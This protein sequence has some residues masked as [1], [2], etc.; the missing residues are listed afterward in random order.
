FESRR[1]HRAEP[2]GGFGTD[3]SFL[4]RVYEKYNAN[5]E[6][7]QNSTKFETYYTG[8]YVPGASGSEY[9]LKATEAKGLTVF[10]NAYG[11]PN[12][13]VW[14]ETM[15]DLNNMSSSFGTDN[16][17][18]SFN[19]IGKSAANDTKTGLA[20]LSHLNN[21][22]AGK[23]KPGQFEMYASTL[24]MEDPKKAAMLVY[25]TAD[26]LKE[27]VG[28]KDNPGIITAEQRNSIMKN[29]ISIINDRNSFNNFLMKENAVT[30]MQAT[31]NAGGYTYKNPGG[32][33]YF[34]IN[35][36]SNGYAITG[37]IGQRDATTGKK[38]FA[39][40]NQIASFGQYGNNIDALVTQL[41]QNLVA[42]AKQNNSI[43]RKFN[44][45]NR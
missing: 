31:I 25:P 11:T 9:A 32:A 17:K 3:G 27:L 29:G 13:N 6:T 39:E 8:T 37:Q 22:M 2:I 15:I 33:G 24:A 23:E 18:I 19:G 12:R 14:T 36:T 42:V 40:I 35:Q 21:K 20:I 16:N 5:Y 43:Y 10:P 30:P 38:T 34:T 7:K 45:V 26:I 28:T 1:M 4:E 44:P 41:Q